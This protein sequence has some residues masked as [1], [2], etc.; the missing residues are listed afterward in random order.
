MVYNNNGYIKLIE[1]IIEDIELDQYY[2][3]EECIKKYNMT[4]PLLYKCI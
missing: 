1:D 2:L 3:I 4:I